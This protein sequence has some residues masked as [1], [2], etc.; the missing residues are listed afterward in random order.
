[1]LCWGDNPDGQLGDGTTTDRS[2]PV[3]VTGL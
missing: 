1:V 3:A 2:A